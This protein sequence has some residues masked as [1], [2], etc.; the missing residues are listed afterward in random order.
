MGCC[1]SNSEVEPACV[2]GA[3][4]ESDR[5]GHF[6]LARH[7]FSQSSETREDS[8]DGYAWRFSA[9]AFE[10]VARFVANERKCCPFVTFKV[11]VE[12]GNG[13]VWLRMTG[14]EGTRAVLQAELDSS[15]SGCC[16]GHEE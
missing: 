7:L 4:P 10:A 8:K 5:E 14:P 6:A 16:Q 11:T 13:P 2:P 1:T 9:G 12:A 3:I 15:T